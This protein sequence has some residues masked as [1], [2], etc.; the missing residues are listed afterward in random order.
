MNKKI[1]FETYQTIVILCAIIGIV[2]IIFMPIVSVS[3]LGY[4]QGFTLLSSDLA[5]VADE[6]SSVSLGI[7]LLWLA[8]ICSI[9]GIVICFYKKELQE[10]A[11]LNKIVYIAQAILLIL[12]FLMII[13]TLSSKSSAYSYGSIHVGPSIGMIVFI[14]TTAISCI[15]TFKFQKSL[16]T[17]NSTGKLKSFTYD[18]QTIKNNQSNVQGMIIGKSGVND[19]K[20]VTIKAGQVILIGRDREKVTIPIDSKIVGRVHCYIKLFSSQ[21]QYLIKSCSRNG[22][23][24]ENGSRL[25]DNEYVA[26]PGGTTIYI[27]SVANTFY[28][29]KY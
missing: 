23:F 26:V 12:A 10:I 5:A 25:P 11:R 18:H 19:T 4:S 2:A 24:L 21:H 29:E 6:Y 15:Y 8:V 28:L 17:I 3:A 13:G 1:K 7:K 16:G 20:K 14:A 9:S 22:T 27:A